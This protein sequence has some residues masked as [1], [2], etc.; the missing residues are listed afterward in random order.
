MRKNTTVSTLY[1]QDIPDVK[2]FHFYDMLEREVINL[3]KWNGLDN[4]IPSHI[5]EKN[6]IEYGKVLFFKHKD[7]GHLALQCEVKDKDLYNRP[8]KSIVNVTAGNTRVYEVRNNYYEDL[9]IID[10]DTQGVLIENELGSKSL[11]PIIS[12]YAQR[13]AVLWTSMDINILWQ[14]LPPIYQATDNDVKLSLEKLVSDIWSG[15]PFI[16]LDR[17][18]SVSDDSVRVGLA[19]VPFI[20]HEL[21][22]AQQQV[23]SDFREYI[24]I[25]TVGTVKESGVKSEEITANSQAISVS[26]DSMLSSRE[27]AVREINKL[28]GLNISVEIVGKGVQEDGTSNNRI[29]DTPE[30]S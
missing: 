21:H 14:N 5:L 30:S 7:Q 16:V 4:I 1:N 15:K 12:F 29:E 28:F 9:E 10:Q 20:F 3:F 23:L 8:T 6:L 22:K 26:L 13:M 25:N 2:Y 11:Q 27:K 18:L 19:G 24:G 17:A